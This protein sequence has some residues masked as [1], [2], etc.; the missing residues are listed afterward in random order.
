MRAQKREPL[1]QALQGI[2]DFV[3]FIF[4]SKMLDIDEHESELVN[5]SHVEHFFKKV[6]TILL[7]IFGILDV[8]FIILIAKTKDYIQM[9]K[10]I[11]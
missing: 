5:L 4:I 10:D 8:R 6:I 2:A 3:H 9:F 1:K 11:S 7:Q